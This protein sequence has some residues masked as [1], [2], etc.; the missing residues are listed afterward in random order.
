MVG[1]VGERD[2]KK[3]NRECDDDLF[4]VSPTDPLC[5]SPTPSPLPLPLIEIRNSLNWAHTTHRE[6]RTQIPPPLS[7]Q[8]AFLSH[9]AWQCGHDAAR[10]LDRNH[11]YRH[12]P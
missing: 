3:T 9:G 11:L 7:P 5:L 1:K 8:P 4:F 12:P 2:E 10:A 6:R